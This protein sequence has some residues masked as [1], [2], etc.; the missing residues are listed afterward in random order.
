MIS[1]GA[2][3]C[4]GLGL[5][6]AMGPGQRPKIPVPLFRCSVVP[7]RC[8]VVLYVI[9]SRTPTTKQ[10]E[11]EATRNDARQQN[12]T[13]KKETAITLSRSPQEPEGGQRL[14]DGGKPA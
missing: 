10:A 6:L 8:S 1:L 9:E 11:S 13:W 3:G 7:F 5:G 14:K 2:C 4:G 12:R